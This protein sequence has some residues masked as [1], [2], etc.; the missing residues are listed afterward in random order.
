MKAAADRGMSLE[1][2]VNYAIAEALLH[3]QTDAWH[4]N[5]SMED[6]AEELEVDLGEFVLDDIACPPDAGE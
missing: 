4:C 3:N 5:I 2:F 1:E 6:L